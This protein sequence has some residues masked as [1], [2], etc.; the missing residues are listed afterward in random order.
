MAIVND[1][2]ATCW[3]VLQAKVLRCNR[4]G[5]CWLL[6]GVSEGRIK[7]KANP[8]NEYPNHC[9]KLQCSW[10]IAAVRGHV[11]MDTRRVRFK[12]PSDSSGS[13]HRTAEAEDVAI[14][15]LRRNLEQS[16]TLRNGYPAAASS[17][18]TGRKPAP[19]D[20]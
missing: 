17:G 8:Q 7:L 11:G 5:S 12:E 14:S 10:P 9:L 13:S 3:P 1:T 20:A 18:V 4:V 19:T 16:S 15:A 2:E 6:T